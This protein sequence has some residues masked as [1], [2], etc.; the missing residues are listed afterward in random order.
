MKEYL[1]REMPP[2][3]IGVLPLSFSD[4]FIGRMRTITLTVSSALPPDA[5]SEQSTY[6]YY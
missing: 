4:L 1:L 2:L 5:M 6:I 3:C